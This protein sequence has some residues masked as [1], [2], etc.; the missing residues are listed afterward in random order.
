M[1][2]SFSLVQIASDDT[3][4]C[5]GVEKAARNVSLELGSMLM[6]VQSG[7]IADLVLVANSEMLNVIGD[8]DEMKSLATLYDQVGDNTI[9]GY[10]TN[11]KQSV[12]HIS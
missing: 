12:K 1:F 4:A 10:T 5:T 2:F 11:M 3:K 6:L 8:S 9:D 7:A